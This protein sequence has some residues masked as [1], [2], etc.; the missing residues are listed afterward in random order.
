MTPVAAPPWEAKRTPETRQ[1]E[2]M[3][4]KRFKQADSYRYNSA[5]IRVR[6]IDLR[7]AR[8]REIPFVGGRAAKRQELGPL[9]KTEGGARY[10]AGLQEPFSRRLLRHGVI[11]L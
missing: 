5:S 4:R 10:R 9:A 3:L 8:H 6:V 7:Y 11:P 1:V 2:D